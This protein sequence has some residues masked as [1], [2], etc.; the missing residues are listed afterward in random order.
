MEAIRNQKDRASDRKV[1]AIKWIGNPP[2]ELGNIQT[3]TVGAVCERAHIDE[4]GRRNDQ[5]ERGIKPMQRGRECENEKQ[6]QVNKIRVPKESPHPGMNGVKSFAF[7]KRVDENACGK[8]VNNAGKPTIQ[9]MYAPSQIHIES[10]ITG[11]VGVDESAQ[12]KQDKADGNALN[13]N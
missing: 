4:A 10:A 7:R 1:E 5:Y 13:E 9:I 6:C 8:P 2:E 11:V 12:E 3:D